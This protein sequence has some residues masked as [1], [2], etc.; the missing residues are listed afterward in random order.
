MKTFCKLLNL[1]FF[2]LI[3]TQASVSIALPSK[4]DLN[5]LNSINDPQINESAATGSSLA[6]GN[7]VLTRNKNLE[8]LCSECRHQIHSPI[9]EP[10]MDSMQMT[11]STHGEA[12]T[13]GNEQGK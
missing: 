8:V 3:F 2:L 7:T 9:A 4:L 11:K 10:P 13:N 1:G 6:T 12:D 5:L